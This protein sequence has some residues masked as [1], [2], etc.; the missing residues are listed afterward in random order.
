MPEVAYKSLREMFEAR[1]E[2]YA[3]STYLTFANEG[4]SFKEFD[5]RVNKCANGLLHLGIGKGD[6]VCV[7]ANNSPNAL[8]AYF[9]IVKI[10]AV[11]G[12]I[13]CWW[14]PPEIKYLLNDSEAVAAIVESSCI[15]SIEQ[16]RP[17]CPHLRIIVEMGDDPKPEYVSFQKMLEENSETLPESHID[18]EDEAFIFYTSGTTGHPKGVL[19]THYNSLHAIASLEE[20]LHQEKGKEVALIFLPIFHVNAMFS[21]IAG[22]NGGV[23]IVLR[24]GFSAS[25]FW[26][27]VERYR[28]TFWSAVP[29][30]YNILLQMPE[31]AAGRD[32]SSVKFGICGAAPMP[33]ET[34]TKFE[35]VFGIKIIE[36][37][38]LTEGTVASAINPVDGERKIGSIG[39]PLPGQQ[40]KILD[41]DGVELPVGEVGELCVG[42]GNVMKGYLRKPEANAETLRGGW[43]RTGD[44]AYADEDGYLFIVDR[45]KEMIIRGGEN[46]YPKEIDNLLF[47]HPKILEAAVIGVADDIMGEEVKAFVVTMPGESMEE[48]EVR[49]FCR[50][51][52]A[53]FK[54]PRY[55]EFIDEL[56]KNIIGKTLK[57]QLKQQH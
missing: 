22:I 25:E 6:I 4:I 50:E 37:Y 57:K 21:L 14:Q 39:K 17:E 10:G 53:S 11:A 45:K 35:E 52:L 28:V 40:I 8:V 49:D 51:N 9:A 33:V 44:M 16:I 55:V 1:T 47:S 42:G 12:P 43:L 19:L 32:L 3:N 26:K 30:V 23:H 29:A 48:E 56:P 15:P 54:V 20:G 36:G 41:D 24:Q 27:I 31:N 7:Y 34:F 5:L 18:L 13:N 2:E 46:I 38:G